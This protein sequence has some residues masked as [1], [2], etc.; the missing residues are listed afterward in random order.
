MSVKVHYIT[1]D[2]SSDELD[3]EIEPE[4]VKVKCEDEGA[5]ASATGLDYEAI[6]LK[7]A[8]IEEQIQGMKEDINKLQNIKKSASVVNRRSPSEAGVSSSKAGALYCRG[9]QTK[10]EVRDVALWRG[11]LLAICPKTSRG[12]N[13]YYILVVRTAEFAK[14]IVSEINGLNYKGRTIKM[15]HAKGRDLDID[16]FIRNHGGY[17]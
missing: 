11:D 12:G 8:N 7:I 15:Q 1:V 5:V 3:Y 9:P 6:S 14:Q 16:H 17:L 4:P 13:L 10:F 2:S